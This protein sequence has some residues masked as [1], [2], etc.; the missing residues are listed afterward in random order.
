MGISTPNCMAS[1]RNHHGIAWR[2]ASARTPSENAGIPL[3]W[4]LV[5]VADMFATEAV[6]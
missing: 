1:D 2:L 5:A 3:T 4:L 6:W